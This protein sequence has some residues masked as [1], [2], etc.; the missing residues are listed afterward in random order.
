MKTANIVVAYDEATR[1]LT[2]NLTLTEFI[3]AL[4]AQVVTAVQTDTVT[5]FAGPVMSASDAQAVNASVA[6]ALASANVELAEWKAASD[7]K[8]KADLIPTP[9]P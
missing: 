3:S 5:L 8:D 1:T 7:N 2:T 9:A 4:P 6:K